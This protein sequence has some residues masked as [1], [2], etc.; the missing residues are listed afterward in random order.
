MTELENID[1][2]D[3]LMGLLRVKDDLSWGNQVPPERGLP[4]TWKAASRLMVKW[5]SLGG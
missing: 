3:Q 4:P 1:W 2:W 5:G